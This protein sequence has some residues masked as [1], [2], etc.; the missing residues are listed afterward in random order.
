MTSAGRLK[1][2][3]LAAV[4]TCLV[5]TVAW[6]ILA[7][8]AGDLKAGHLGL[9]GC[10]NGCASEQPNCVSGP[11]LS[12]EPGATWYWMRS[13]DEEKRVVIGLYNRYCI[14]CHGVDGRGIWDIPDVPDFTNARWQASRSDAPSRHL[15]SSPS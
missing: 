11:L 14:R 3:A 2:R 4:G 13:P 10:R 9:R 5:F 8:S 1:R 15:P 6:V 7:V 12:E